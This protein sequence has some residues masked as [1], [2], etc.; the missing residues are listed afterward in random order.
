MKSQTPSEPLRGLGIL[1]FLKKPRGSGDSQRTNDPGLPR[2]ILRK[3]DRAQ[4]DAELMEI[5]KSDPLEEVARAAYKRVDSQKELASHIRTMTNRPRQLLAL[6]CLTD[7]RELK[8][9]AQSLGEPLCVEVV[10]RI[11]D[12]GLLTA[13]GED[14][15]APDAARCAAYEK[16][17]QP[18]MADGMR[19]ASSRTL[20]PERERAA[21]RILQTGD[22]AL[23]TRVAEL[24]LASQETPQA[25]SFVIRAS[26]VCPDEML[27]LAYNTWGMIPI[28]VTALEALG[29]VDEAQLVRLTS[30]SI[31]E[32]ER[33]SAA[34]CILESGDE[35]LVEKA[36]DIVLSGR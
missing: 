25:R 34:A 36:T 11:S 12:A 1:N 19:L 17:N 29:R 3:L 21:E 23:I 7:Q 9:L 32:N 31:P 2:K 22:T 26:K 24:V 8:D 15:K 5:G 14:K 33:Q 28:K 27:Q 30:D 16:L 20:P 35:T 4:G 13:L 6:E 18:R 10:K